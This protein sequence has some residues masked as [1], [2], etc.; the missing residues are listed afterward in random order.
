MPANLSL[1][2]TINSLEAIFSNN[3]RYMLLHKI[4]LSISIR[5][6][7]RCLVV[8][9]I[10]K[11]DISFGVPPTFFKSL[12]SSISRSWVF[13]DV[14]HILQMDGQHLV[15]VPFHCPLVL[16]VFSG[17]SSCD[18]NNVLSLSFA[19]SLSSLLIPLRW[20]RLLLF[21]RGT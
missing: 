10:T 2:A 7:L 11:G 12:N 5:E 21:F 14:T 20:S 13:V 18:R 15:D 3:S 8:V 17:R 19:I 9:V 1:C 16:D 6:T 4:P